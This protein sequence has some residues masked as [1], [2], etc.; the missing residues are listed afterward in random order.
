MGKSASVAALIVV[1]T[2]AV[3]SE[4]GLCWEEEA[5]E[6]MNHAV[7]WARDKFSEGLKIRQDTAQNVMDKAG[8]AASRATGTIINQDMAQNG[9]DEAGDAASRATGTINSAASETSKY[10][11]EKAGE[12]GSS[13]SEHAKEAIKMASETA[14]NAK[15]SM[16]D[17]TGYGKD[18]KSANADSATMMGNWKSNEI[19]EAYEEALKRVGQSYGA[20]KET[21]SDRAKSTYEA[22][23]EAASE[24]TG[25]LGSEMRKETAE[26]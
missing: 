21:V 20:A 6:R 19:E 7:D 16:Q 24:A 5:K 26:L 22:A 14:N 3:C 4:V 8:D 25:K 23:K 9:M 10:V 15:E 2:M 11:S 17:I 18:E 12:M 13:T 1:L